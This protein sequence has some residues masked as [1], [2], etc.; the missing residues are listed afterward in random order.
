MVIKWYL[1]VYPSQRKWKMPWC[2]AQLIK[3][4]SQY[5]KVEDSVL[6]EGTYKKQSMNAWS[7]MTK[8][9]FS[10]SLSLSLSLHP[11]SF[12]CVFKNQQNKN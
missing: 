4:L 10:L 12:L 11:L 9:C 2:V 5:A 7:G 8:G 3:A 6:G 1:R